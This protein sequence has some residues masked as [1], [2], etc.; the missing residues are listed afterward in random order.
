MM[1]TILASNYWNGFI[2]YWT[3]SFKK[4]SGFTMAIIA[5]GFIGIGIIMMGR[6]KLDS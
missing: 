5:V 1:Y 3:E 4:Q 2:D 6:K